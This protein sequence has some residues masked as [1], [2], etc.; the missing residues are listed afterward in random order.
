MSIHVSEGLASCLH[1]A[2]DRR[3]IIA[4]ALQKGGEGG[5]RKEKVQLLHD[6]ARGRGGPAGPKAAYPEG[7]PL[8]ARGLGVEQEVTCALL[9]SMSL[10]GAPGAGVSMKDEIGWDAVHRAAC[11]EPTIVYSVVLHDLIQRSSVVKTGTH[12]KKSK[13]SE[14]GRNKH[15]KC[16]DSENRMEYE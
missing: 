6:D 5:G 10:D 1:V 2:E 9:A 4:H 13:G 11:G 7:L 16:T 8:L 15:N 12:I 3:F 14:G